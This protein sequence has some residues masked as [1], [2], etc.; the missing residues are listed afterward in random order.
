M[1]VCVRESREP[2]NRLHLIR[3]TSYILRIRDCVCVC[4]CERERESVKV[5]NFNKKLLFSSDFILSVATICRLPNSCHYG[6]A[7]ISRLL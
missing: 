3:Q 2:M 4:V 6:V 7:S 1:Y 5:G